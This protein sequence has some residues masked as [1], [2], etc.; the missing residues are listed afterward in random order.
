MIPYEY[1]HRGGVFMELVQILKALG[2]ESRIRILNIL[3]DGE[4][5]VGEIEYI[6]G[7]TQSNASR[8]LNKLFYLQIIKCEKKAQWVFYKINEDK[9]KRFPFIK[10]IIKVEF[11]NINV[12]NEDRRKLLCYKQ[13]GMT[14]EDLKTCK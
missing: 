14:C 13:S 5:C 12:C 9:V 6:L 11:Q 4:L 2:E 7:M 3:I 1:N 8:H 10:E